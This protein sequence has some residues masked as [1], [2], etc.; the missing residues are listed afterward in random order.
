MESSGYIASPACR[1]TADVVRKFG[2]KNPFNQWWTCKFVEP[3]NALF[4]DI[5]VS[6]TAWRADQ[7][8]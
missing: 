4:E 1:R 2:S 3:R 7:G 8:A 6:G 5:V